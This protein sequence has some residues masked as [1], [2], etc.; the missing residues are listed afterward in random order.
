M[1][2][3]IAK[4]AVVFHLNLTCWADWIVMILLFVK[5]HIQGKPSINKLVKSAL[6]SQSKPSQ[7]TVQRAPLH[8]IAVTVAPVELLHAR[9]SQQSCVVAASCIL[10]ANLLVA[11][12]LL[13]SKWHFATGN[14]GVS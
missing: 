2:A 11:I 7:G 13:M 8:G 12:L 5:K 3:D 1:C 10:A 6:T 4:S 9:C 14:L